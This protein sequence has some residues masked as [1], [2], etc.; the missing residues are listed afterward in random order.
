MGEELKELSIADRAQRETEVEKKWDSSP[1]ATWS[2][3]R[4]RPSRQGGTDRRTDTR[5]DEVGGAPLPQK[6]PCPALELSQRGNRDNYR[7]L[8]WTLT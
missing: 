3:A 7:G 4:S 1:A 8:D 6:A 5:L 2:G